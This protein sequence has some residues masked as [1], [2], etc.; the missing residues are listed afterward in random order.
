MSSP[1]SS[2]SLLTAST[3]AS[4]SVLASQE[5]NDTLRKSLS[6]EFTRLK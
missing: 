3:A 1:A 2:L 6:A 5:K 4:L